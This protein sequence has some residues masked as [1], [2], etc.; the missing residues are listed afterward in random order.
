[1]LL[2]CFRLPLNSPL[3]LLPVTCTAPQIQTPLRSH[4]LL[5]HHEQRFDEM[6]GLNRSM[7][8][9]ENDIR[10]MESLTE[11]L[12]SRNTALNFERIRTD[13]A[14]VLAHVGVQ[15]VPWLVFS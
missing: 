1:M 13:L 9:Y 11:T 2:G 3:L 6:V 5:P 14:Q 15:F 7:G 10:G 4:A 12:R 8:K